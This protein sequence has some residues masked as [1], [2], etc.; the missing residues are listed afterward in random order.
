MKKIITI[1]LILGAAL[2]LVQPV[3]AENLS[4]TEEQTVNPLSSFIAEPAESSIILIWETTTEIDTVGFNLYRAEAKDGEYIRLNDSL[5]IAEGSES[6]GFIYEF[7]DEGVQNLKTYSYIL[8][9]IDIYGV[10]T[11]H[12]PVSATPRLIYEEQ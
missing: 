7:D 2:L 11:L 4:Q 6:E 12:G 8:E 10:S 9:D 1:L 5:M 3:K